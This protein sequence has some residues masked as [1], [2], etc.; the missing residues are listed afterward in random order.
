MRHRQKS[1]LKS[2]GFNRYTVKKVHEQDI[3]TLLK[4]LRDSLTSDFSMLHIVCI[5]EDVV[6]SLQ[7]L[8]RAIGSTDF[9]ATGFNPLR[10]KPGNQMECRRYDTFNCDM[11]RTY[12][13]PYRFGFIFPGLKS[14]VTISSEATPLGRCN[15]LLNI[16]FN[17]IVFK[18]L[19]YRATLVEK[20]R[21]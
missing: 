12:G 16:F 6:L 15:S 20:P 5:G 11:R 9:V 13:S 8:L 17:R 3:S 4:S 10:W 18:T 7:L 19:F 1:S 21:A 2:V 14:G